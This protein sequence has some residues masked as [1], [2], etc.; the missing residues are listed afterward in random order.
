MDISSWNLVAEKLKALESPDFC[1][2]DK[3]EQS[4]IRHDLFG[5]DEEIYYTA[6]EEEETPLPPSSDPGDFYREYY[7]FMHS[8]MIG[9]PR[10]SL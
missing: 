6:I 2:L 9:M 3:A 8:S 7:P 10:A 4:R 1:L 5:Y